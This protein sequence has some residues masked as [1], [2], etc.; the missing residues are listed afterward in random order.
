MSREA[1]GHTGELRGSGRPSIAVASVRLTA[2]PASPVS[3][4]FPAAAPALPPVHLRGAGGGQANVGAT[5]SMPSSGS[6]VLRGRGIAPVC[7]GAH[8]LAPSGSTWAC[9]HPMCPAKSPRSAPN[10]VKGEGVSGCLLTP[11]QVASRAI[12][13]TTARLPLCACLPACALQGAPARRAGGC[14]SSTSRG[15]RGHLDHQSHAKRAFQR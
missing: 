10:G 13:L 2:I 4:S 12:S 6:S 8:L 7:G 15:Q 11:D 1:G 14:I 3:A 9:L 5:R